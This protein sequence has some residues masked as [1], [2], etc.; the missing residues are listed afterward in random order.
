[1]SDAERKGLQKKAAGYKQLAHNEEWLQG[2]P[3]KSKKPG[4]PQKRNE[5]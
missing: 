3:E 2:E 1:M 5:F 4:A